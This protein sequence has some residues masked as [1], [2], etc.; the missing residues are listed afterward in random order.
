M[1][2]S[3]SARIVRIPQAGNVHSIVGNRRG[4]RRTGGKFLRSFHDCNS[5]NISFLLK[6][7][8]QS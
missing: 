5:I 8:E 4:V 3:D 6:T 1:K 7:S 2:V